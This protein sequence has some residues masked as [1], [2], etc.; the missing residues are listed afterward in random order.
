MAN[1]Y[2]FI[3]IN[4]C[5]WVSFLCLVFASNQSFCSTV[6]CQC[7]SLA[8]Q[9]KLKQE[10]IQNLDTLLQTGLEWMYQKQ[11]TVRS[12][13]KK[14]NLP[15]FR[16]LSL[17]CWSSFFILFWYSC[18]VPAKREGNLPKVKIYGITTFA[19]NIQRYYPIMTMRCLCRVRANQFSS[20]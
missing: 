9:T 12:V 17:Y 15:A 20:Y 18:S 16:S 7:S 2:I 1:T 14:L 4:L 3:Y 11:R 19:L 13:S 8:K 5:I 10:V 6:N